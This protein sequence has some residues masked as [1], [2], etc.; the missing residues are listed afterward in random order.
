MKD[1]SPYDPVE[2]NGSRGEAFKPKVSIGSSWQVVVEPGGDNHFSQVG[3]KEAC[4]DKPWRPQASNQL[5]RMVGLDSGSFDLTLLL[6]AL[7]NLM[8]SKAD[9][10]LVSFPLVEDRTVLEEKL[11][12]FLAQKSL[13]AKQIFS[14]AVELWIL[15]EIFKTSVLQGLDSVLLSLYTKLD[16]DEIKCVDSFYVLGTKEPEEALR[17]LA[18]CG[19]KAEQQIELQAGLGLASKA[20]VFRVLLGPEEKARFWDS[21]WLI[22]G[23]SSGSGC[24]LK[25]LCVLRVGYALQGYGEGAYG[26]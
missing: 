12:G 24:V 18:T 3:Q 26:L 4:W 20:I 15:Q 7:D 5:D 1:C 21:R 6:D 11:Q 19:L 23:S 22:A 13:E 25:E 14:C 17:C 10:P 16:E 8:I 2:P 9:A